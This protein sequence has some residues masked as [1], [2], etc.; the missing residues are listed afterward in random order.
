LITGSIYW[1]AYLNLCLLLMIGERLFTMLATYY[2]PCL[3][4][5]TPLA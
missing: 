2:Y 3:F 1:F 5:A 4:E